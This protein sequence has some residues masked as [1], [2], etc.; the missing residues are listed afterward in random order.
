MG[1][2]NIDLCINGKL[3]AKTQKYEFAYKAGYLEISN[4]LGGQTKKVAL[5]SGNYHIMSK[6]RY[7]ERLLRLEPR[8]A[9][10]ISDE[11]ILLSHKGKILNINAE[12]GEIKVEHKYKAGMN[13]PLVFCKCNIAENSWV[14]YGEYG[15][16][17]NMGEVSIYRRD[18]Q[19]KWGKKQ[20]F[21]ENSIAHI[22]CI[23]HDPYR[24]CFLIA[25]GDSDQESGIWMMDEDFQNIK[26]V[27]TGKQDYR[28]CFILPTMEGFVYATDTPLK[29]N[30]VYKYKYGGNTEPEKLYDMPG[31]C[32]YAKKV[33]SGF[34]MATSVEPDS[35]LPVWR[36]RFTRKLGKGVRDHFSHLIYFDGKSFKEIFKAQKDVLPIWLFQFANFQF[37]DMEVEDADFLTIT[38]TAVKKYDGKTIRVMM[39]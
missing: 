15:W 14:L 4:H 35:S 33:K 31:P 12:N 13:N 18:S 5:F 1:M 37:P 32:I 36:Y 23:V 39:K 34:V 29:Q 3:L 30:A 24:H 2:N 21:P 26:P 16:N 25:T 9:A 11:T 7:L 22:H 27:I 10:V 6:I 17:E 19:G 28:T 8:C 20:S 38:S